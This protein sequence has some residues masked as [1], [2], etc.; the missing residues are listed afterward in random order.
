M[1]NGA[2]TQAGQ[3]R[4]R[5]GFARPPGRGQRPVD[6]HSRTPETRVPVEEREGRDTGQCDEQRRLGEERRCCDGARGMEECA[7]DEGHDAEPAPQ[8][9]ARKV[10]GSEVRGRLGSRM[11]FDRSVALGADSMTVHRDGTRL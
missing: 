6:R 8:D 9:A 4:D 2:P 7:E 1:T 3:Q 5:I 10:V 11:A